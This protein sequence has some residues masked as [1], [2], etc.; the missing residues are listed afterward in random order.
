MKKT[1]EEI[2]A[3]E[4]A[5]SQ[6]DVGDDASSI[7]A[8]SKYRPKSCNTNSKN[9]P[10]SALSRKRQNERKQKGLPVENTYDHA[11]AVGFEKIDPS[12]FKPSFFETMEE[13][14]YSRYIEGD[15]FKQPTFLETADLK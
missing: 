4:S 11:M 2:K 9:R 3:Y 10:K 6:A 13:L 14:N 8:G 5:K 1:P 12:S 15:K 7:F